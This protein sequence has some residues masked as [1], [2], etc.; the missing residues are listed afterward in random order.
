MANDARRRSRIAIE[1]PRDPLRDPIQNFFFDPV[2]NC[3]TNQVNNF[4][5]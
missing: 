4:I 2:N 3:L 1:M 5:I